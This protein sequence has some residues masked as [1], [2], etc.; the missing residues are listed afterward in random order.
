MGKWTEAAKPVKEKIDANQLIVDTVEQ[1]GGIRTELT[2]SDKLGYDWN[3]FYVNDI[4][5]RKEYVE[6][7]PPRGTA[8]YP[9]EWNENVICITNAFY[10]YNGVRKVWCGESGVTAS[11][12]DSNWEE[13]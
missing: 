12:E 2:Q 10:T 3:C 6:Q 1:A 9:I 13:F 4:L 11:W 5:V 7:N 8:E